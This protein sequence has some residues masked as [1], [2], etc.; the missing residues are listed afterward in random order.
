MQKEF[1]GIPEPAQSAVRLPELVAETAELWAF[2]KPSGWWSVPG[3]PEASEPPPCLSTW[4][5]HESGQ[6]IWIV[7]RLDR[8]TSG[9]IVFAKDAAAHRKWCGLFESRSIQKTYRAWVHGKLLMPMA[10]IKSPLDGKPSRTQIKRLAVRTVAEWGE[11]TEVEIALLTGRQHQARRHLAEIGHP[12]IGDSVYGDAP[13][14]KRPFEQA[15]HAWRLACSAEKFA[16][17]APLPP[18]W[19]HVWR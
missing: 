11:V 13:N 15:L 5:E 17:E 16:V 18:N 12:V 4:W 8:A 3:R 10:L 19:E 9:I 7:H 2:N 1:Q 14:S 6:K